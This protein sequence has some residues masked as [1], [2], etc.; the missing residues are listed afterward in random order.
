MED[1]LQK[2]SNT[3]IVA[4]SIV[5]GMAVLLFLGACAALY[6]TKRRRQLSKK[7]VLDDSS[8]ETAPNSR[9]AIRDYMTKRSLGNRYPSWHQPLLYSVPSSTRPSDNSMDRSSSSIGSGNLYT[10]IP[11]RADGFS[12]MARQRGCSLPSPLSREEFSYGDT[13]TDT[14]QLPATPS[15]MPAS[16]TKANRNSSASASSTETRD[17]STSSGNVSSR[18]PSPGHASLVDVNPSPTPKRAPSPV[19]SIQAEEA[20]SVYSLPSACH[21]ILDYSRPSLPP[22]AVTTNTALPPRPR[23]RSHLRPKLRLESEPVPLARGDTRVVSQL[24]KARARRSTLEV[25]PTIISRTGSTVSR[26][27]RKGSIRSVPGFP[28]AFMPQNMPEP[29]M[30]VLSEDQ[31]QD[32]GGKTPRQ[33][34]LTGPR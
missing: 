9:E 18:D 14:V 25:E 27:E 22:A 30:F 19:P 32:E 21:S 17:A 3:F 2:T 29:E 10:R 15:P 33:G 8:M 26:I 16:K 23:P 11:E 31:E 4:A 34:S 13:S 20:P 6:L 7:Q 12:A 5:A 28:D 24:L 1:K